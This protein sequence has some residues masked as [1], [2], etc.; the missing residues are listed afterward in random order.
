MPDEDVQKGT[1]TLLS[2]EHK[3]SSIT[4]RFNTDFAIKNSKIL[5]MLIY[6]F[7]HESL[8]DSIK[9]QETENY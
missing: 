3:F 7:P 2:D 5:L 1:Q 9:S 8:F 4:A 6:K